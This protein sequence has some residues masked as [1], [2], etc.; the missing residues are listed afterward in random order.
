[1]SFSVMLIPHEHNPWNL[2]VETFIDAAR[3]RFPAATIGGPVEHDGNLFVQLNTRDDD[4]PGVL[5]ELSVE[6][7]KD[8]YF[9]IRSGTSPQAAEVFSFVR[10]WL[11]PHQPAQILKTSGDAV[12]VDV[13]YGAGPEQILAIIGALT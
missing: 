2:D 13:P 4:D 11:G 8:G 12:P 1:M 3:D 6:P 5:A 9:S 10:D 7:T